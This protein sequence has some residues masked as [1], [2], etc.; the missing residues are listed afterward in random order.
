MTKDKKKKDVKVKNK[1][2]LNPN[3]NP[4]V[5]YWCMLLLTLWH[6]DADDKANDGQN[7]KQNDQEAALLP[8]GFGLE[9]NNAWLKLCAWNKTE[10]P[11][12]HTKMKHTVHIVKQGWEGPRNQLAQNSECTV[13]SFVFCSNVIYADRTTIFCVRICFPHNYISTC[14]HAVYPPIQAIPCW[15]QGL[16]GFK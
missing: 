4:A 5:S 6:W 7:N 14:V 2:Y 12:T 9:Q 3:P 8:P 11:G 10:T 16:R 1:T 13:F 15:L